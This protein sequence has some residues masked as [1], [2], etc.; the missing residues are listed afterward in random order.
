MFHDRADI[1]TF[2]GLETARIELAA[3]LGPSD[4]RSIPHLNAAIRDLDRVIPQVL[5]RPDLR[6]WR[7]RSRRLLASFLGAGEESSSRSAALLGGAVDDLEFF[8]RSTDDDAGAWEDLAEARADRVRHLDPAAAR[9]GLE[10]GVSD[11]RRAIAIDP[12]RKGRLE[13][14]IEEFLEAIGDL[15]DR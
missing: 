10:R 5:D 14:R 7:G 11:L 8:L 6:R 12:G 4:P 1:R 13:A 3:H 2:V 15:E 9:A